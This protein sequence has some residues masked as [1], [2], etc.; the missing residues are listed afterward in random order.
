L[1]NQRLLVFFLSEIKNEFFP[2]MTMRKYIPRSEVNNLVL[3]VENKEV[4]HMIITIGVDEP[5]RLV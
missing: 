4:E 1:E 3:D 2:A 5:G